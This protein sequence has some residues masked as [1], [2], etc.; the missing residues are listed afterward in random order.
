LVSEA[1][2]P[3]PKSMVR[4]RINDATGA[5][6]DYSDNEGVFEYFKSDSLDVQ[7]SQSNIS[8]EFMVNVFE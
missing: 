7:A 6:T 3:L 4:I 8:D 1:P 5:V 2:Q